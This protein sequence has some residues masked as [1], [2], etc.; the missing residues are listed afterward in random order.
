MNYSK[1]LLIVVGFIA[2]A[3]VLVAQ[4]TS[5]MGSMAYE[6]Y[7]WQQPR[8]A[9]SFSVVP[10]PSGVNVS[11]EQVFNKKSVLRGVTELKRR[12][13]DLPSGASI[14]WPDRIS[15][16]TGEKAKESA[17]LSYPSAEIMQDIK[18]YAE[19]HKIKVEVL[20]GQ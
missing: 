4:Q 19:A 1:I 10:S 7:S 5:K 8:G 13:S 16:N 14:L 2:T 17:K 9:W 3:M 20:S 15:L 18:R 11:A 12:I 6:L